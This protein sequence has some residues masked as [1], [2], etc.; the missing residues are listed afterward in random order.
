MGPLKESFVIYN[1]QGHSKGMAVVSFQRARDA[2]VACAKYDGKIVDGR[3][4]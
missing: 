4:Y 2:E 3:E 1:S